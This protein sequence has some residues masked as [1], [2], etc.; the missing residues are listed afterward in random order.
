MLLLDT[1]HFVQ[2]NS[3]GGSSTP[4]FNW[5]ALASFVISGLSLLLS[6]IGAYRNKQVEIVAKRFDKLCIDPIDAGF[7]ELDKLFSTH[8]NELA[9]NYLKDVATRLTEVNLVLVSLRS[10][11]PA[12]DAQSV[13]RI[14]D[15]FSD[16]YF[17]CKDEQVSEYL[18]S[19]LKA[20]NLVI[21]SLY[22]YILNEELAL[23][24]RL[25]GEWNSAKSFVG[26]LFKRQK[27]SQA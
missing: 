7:K 27:P 16:H 19:Y 25:R 18:A 5:L 10:I 9:S 22:K 3:K 20:K 8:G 23:R 12:L 17:E 26:D 13:T 24:T 21:D 2:N 6:F 15:A 4:P 14:N 1:I 11:Y